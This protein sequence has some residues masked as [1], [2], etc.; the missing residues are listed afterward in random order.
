MRTNFNVSLTVHL[1][2]T[3]PNDQ[4]DAQLFL[5]HLLQ[6]STRFEQ[7]LIHPQ[8]VEIVLTF[9]HRSFIFKF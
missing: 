3:L 7:Y 1:S 2:I 5:I 9:W 6:S 4:L 8:E